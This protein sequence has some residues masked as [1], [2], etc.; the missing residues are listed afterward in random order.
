MHAQSETAALFRFDGFD[1]AVLLEARCATSPPH[2]SQHSAGSPTSK[3]PENEMNKS[4][5]LA[6]LQKLNVSAWPLIDSS[7]SFFSSPTDA[8]HLWSP[9]GPKRL[10]FRKDQSTQ[11]SQLSELSLIDTT[12]DP[13]GA[14]P[15]REIS[16]LITF[17]FI[18]TLRIAPQG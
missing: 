6:K 11:R 17:L 3:I 10:N 14:G 16:S 8:L 13:S 5:S 9:M 1:L 4:K 15:L 12:L 18:P 2:Q 7:I